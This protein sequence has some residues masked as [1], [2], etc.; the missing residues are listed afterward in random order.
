[1]NFARPN[2]SGERENKDAGLKSGA[3][4]SQLGS[5]WLLLI[6]GGQCLIGRAQEWSRFIEHNGDGNVAQEAF[7]FPFV[8]EGVKKSAVLHFSRILTAMPPAT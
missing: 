2:K 3:T 6:D 8:L 1:M 4:R 7:E 5:A